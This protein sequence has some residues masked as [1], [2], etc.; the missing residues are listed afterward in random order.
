MI[1]LQ[2]NSAVVQLKIPLK[3]VATIPLQYMQVW[4]AVSV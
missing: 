4:S 1:P 3:S 2:E